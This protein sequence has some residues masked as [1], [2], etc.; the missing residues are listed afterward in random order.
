MR[1]LSNPVAQFAAAVL[2]AFLLVASLT[3]WFGSRAAERE[4]IADARSVTVVLAQGVVEP[5][6]TRGL[7]DGDPGA[8]AA[9]DRV[10][11][12]RLPSQAVRRVKLWSMNGTIVYSDEPR[13][14]GR[15]FPLG[16]DERKVLANG[17]SDAEI[18]D[19]SAPENVFDTGSGD[20]V[21]VYTRVTSPPEGDPLL[22]EAYFSLADV[23]ARKAEIVQAFRPVTLG[24]TLVLALL[25]TPLA[26]W[27]TRRLR[28]DAR[29]RETLLR[30]AV[31][32]SDGERRRI[33]RDLHD[34][35]VQDLTGATFALAATTRGDRPDPEALEQIGRTMRGSLRALRSL[36]VEIYPPDLH[37]TGLQGALV[38]LL[39]PLEAT[40]ITVEL[41]VDDVPDPP[42]GTAALVWRVAQEAVRNAVRHGHPSRLSVAVEHLGSKVRLSVEDD[43]A[44]FDPHEASGGEHLG[45]RSMRDLARE[46]GGTLDIRSSVGQGTRVRLEVGT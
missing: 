9:F 18:S 7:A 32:A 4:A 26:W 1:L 28:R 46:A 15:R 5:A 36:L 14:V 34:S 16:E 42:G 8:L 37:E 12:E 38:D 31:E 35:V 25:A 40:G 41:R 23:N 13:L 20:L 27:L 33:A 11:Q 10:I 43:G 22:F 17:G 30:A 29:A 3:S 45:L 2:V 19:L 44:G 39:A 21:E 6:M 24:G